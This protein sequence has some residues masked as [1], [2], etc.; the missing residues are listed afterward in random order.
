MQ[1][2]R[3]TRLVAGTHDRRQP[4]HVAHAHDVYV[5]LTAER[6][7]QS[8]VD[9]QRNVALVLLVGSQH[10]ES[11]VVGVPARASRRW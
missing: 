3:R 1:V 11:H 5:V 6:L 2:P 4:L 8:E 7:D 10:A 9:L